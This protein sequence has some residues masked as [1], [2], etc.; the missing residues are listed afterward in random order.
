MSHHESRSDTEF[1]PKIAKLAE[2]E[3]AGL[4]KY[5]S[6]KA[7]RRAKNFLMGT[8]LLAGMAWGGIA[9][10]G[11]DGRPHEDEHHGQGVTVKTGGEKGVTVTT[12]KESAGG[13]VIHNAENKTEKPDPRKKAETPGTESAG[14][15]ESRESH[16]TASS[17]WVDDIVKTASAE[18][19]SVHSEGDA[20]QVVPSIIAQ[21]ESEIDNPTKGDLRGTVGNTGVRIRIYTPEDGKHLKD[22]ITKI[23]SMIQGLDIRLNL[24]SSATY[25]DRIQAMKLKVANQSTLER[26]Q[27]V[28]TLEK[29]L[30]QYK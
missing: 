15:A 2:E 10:G 12:G 1:D 9:I 25:R 17:L 21:L 30:E 11:S 28:E 5:G 20:D 6:S 23:E 26:T 13:I 4:S 29:A 16:L 27:Q 22:A 18:L 14:H 24:D 7:G 19:S 3:K 8:A